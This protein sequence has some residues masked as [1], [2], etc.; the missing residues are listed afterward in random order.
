MPLAPEAFDEDCARAALVV[1][2]RQAPGGCQAVLI[3]RNS[4]REHGAAAVRFNGEQV[5][6]QQARSRGY[7]RPWAQAPRRSPQAVP[8]TQDA[9][10]PLNNLEADD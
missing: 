1:S 7:Q 3:D 5:E 8:Q 9:T 6:I 4:L 10:P 2:P